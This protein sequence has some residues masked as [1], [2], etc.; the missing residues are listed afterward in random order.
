MK[1]K[2]ITIGDEIL[3]GQIV[4]TNSAWLG[5][6]LQLLGVEVI[7][8]QSISDQLEHIVQSLTLSFEQAD[9]IIMTGGLGP[10]KD[11]ITKVAIAKYFGVGMSFHEP[12]WERIERFFEKLGRSTT[13]A[14]RA[15]CDMPENAEI[16]S[17]DMGSAP[18]MLFRKGDKM[19]LSMPGVP[20]EMKW[21]FTNQMLPI[22]QPLL[23]EKAIAH[24]TILTAGEGESRIAARIE[25]IE[26]G[27]PSNVKLAFLPGLAAVRLRLSAQ[28]QQQE[29]V[30]QQV[31]AER[32]KI[33]NRI[34]ELIFGH[35][36]EVLAVKIG[37]LLQERQM[38][39]GLAESCTGGHLSQLIT[40][41]S[42]SSAYYAGGLVTYT[43]DLKMR[44]LDVPEAVFKEHGAVSEQCVEA[45]V[46]GALNSLQVDVAVAIS[47]IAGPTGGTATK[48]VG[49]IWM[50][51][52]DKQAIRTQK[53][54]LSKDRRLNIQYASN[55]ALNL[56]RKFLLAI[57]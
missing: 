22:L 35:D 2:I 8:I 32:V 33:A 49:T 24:R 6:Q 13:P 11:D 3:I 16:L 29:I 31:E 43:N 5:A 1:A 18:G 26:A 17:N 10:T 45:M 50:A 39:L 44:L 38:M 52:G 36:K 37:E 14:H 53:L 47:G 12:T 40:A 21:I 55:S 4:D 15:Q 9:L 20:H 51:V 56:L 25:D 46:Q 34:P 30:D 57:E 42:G 48:P 7:E 54:S 41:N 28:G 23:T 19:L 27:L